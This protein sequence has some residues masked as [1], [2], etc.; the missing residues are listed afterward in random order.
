MASQPG[1][2]LSSTV[3]VAPGAVHD[4][5]IS[6]S[7][8]DRALAIA[9]EKALEAWT[10]PK[11]VATA[12]L[13]VFRD[14]T[15]MTGIAYHKAIHRHLQQSKKLI[16]L[17]SPAARAS[18]YVNEEIRQFASMKGADNIIPLLI[19]IFPTKLRATNSFLS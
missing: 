10:P 11:S 18:P 7:R 9:L 13:D 15:D 14:E 3:D 19:D 2:A 1:P 5:F 17:C 6:Y 4:A 8:K 12:R 16:V